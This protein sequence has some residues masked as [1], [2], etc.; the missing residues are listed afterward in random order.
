MRP[1]DEQVTLGSASPL[2]GLDEKDMA[3]PVCRATASQSAPPPPLIHQST[4]NES[5]NEIMA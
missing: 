5:T 2:S 3:E 1:A 4:P